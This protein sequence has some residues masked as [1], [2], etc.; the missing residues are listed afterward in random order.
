[1]DLSPRPAFLASVAASVTFGTTKGS[2]VRGLVLLG[3]V[4]SVSFV[5]FVLVS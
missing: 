4:R 1:M 5:V 3:V 2:G